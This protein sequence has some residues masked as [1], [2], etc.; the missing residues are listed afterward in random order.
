MDERLVIYFLF[1]CL[2]IFLLFVSLCF[3]FVFVFWCASIGYTTFFP[4][5]IGF[6]FVSCSYIKFVIIVIGSS[7]IIIRGN[8]IVI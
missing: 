1:A 5:P 4:I 6:I 2:V 7:K 8:I 3:F